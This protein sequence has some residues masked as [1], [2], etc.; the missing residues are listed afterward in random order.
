MS[1]LANRMFMRYLD[2]FAQTLSNQKR[3]EIIAKAK[4]QKTHAD[5]LP[6]Y[7]TLQNNFNS[8]FK[9]KFNLEKLLSLIKRDELEEEW[10]MINNACTELS[11][12]QKQLMDEIED[13]MFKFK[14]VH[15]GEDNQSCEDC[16]C[17]FCTAMRFE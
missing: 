15:I 9:I 12:I 10:I 6:Y 3:E 16:D 11:Y 7:K 1:E 17:E 5:I 13:I 8:V 14:P 4:K 2:A